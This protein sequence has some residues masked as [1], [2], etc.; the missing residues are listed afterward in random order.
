MKQ[1]TFTYQMGRAVKGLTVTATDE[2]E[3]TRRG[4]LIAT[5]RN[6]D[7]PTTYSIRLRRA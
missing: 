2:Q 4:L 1:Y 6:G 5:K 3:A 7:N